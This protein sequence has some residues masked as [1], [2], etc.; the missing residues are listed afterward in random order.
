MSETNGVAVD[1]AIAD[2]GRDVIL[3]LRT[4]G[5]D[6]QSSNVMQNI[7]EAERMWGSIGAVEPPYNP[8]TLV[9]L[10]EHS[11]SLRQNVDAYVT[12]IDAFGH[13]FEPVLDLDA[14][15]ADDKIANE[16]MTERDAADPTTVADPSR[17]TARPTEDEI[18]ARKK[19]LVE[20]MREERIRLE[21]FFE[22]ST[23]DISFS[24]LRRRT[25]QDIETIGNGYWEVIRDE[26]G[27][28][29]QFEYM[30][31]F[32]IRLLPLDKTATK[33]N[34]RMK[35]GHFDYEEVNVHRRFR[36]FAQVFENRTM[37]FKEFGDPRRFSRK[38][39]R[40][41][42]DGEDFSEEQIRFGDG[43]AT[44][45][46]HFKIH[47]PRSAYGVPRWI[48][49]LLAVLGS[50][51]AEEINYLYFE[52]KSVPP[53]ALLVSGGRVTDETV[54]RIESHIQNEIQ[55]KR[56]FHKVL[57]LEAESPGAGSTLEHSGRMKIE[58]KPLTAAQHNDALFQNYDERNLDKVG[59][60]FRLPRL[61]RGD[62]RDF[63]RATAEAALEFAEMQVFG[64][65]RDEFDFL[66]NRK[67][68]PELDIR[69]WKYKSHAPTTRNPR[70][71]GEIVARLSE[72]NVLT[73]AEAR[74]F[75]EVIFN[76]ELRKDNAPWTRQP[77]AFTLAGI[78]PPEELAAP[79]MARLDGTTAPPIIPAVAPPKGSS[80]TGTDVAVIT[81]VNEARADEM[82]GPL[83]R[84]GP[85]GQMVEDPDGYLTVAEFKAKR[86]ARGESLGEAQG[87]TAA[88][89]GLQHVPG[90]DG[91]EQKADATTG[92][93]ATGG[94]LNLGGQKDKLRR[95]PAS[96][97]QEAVYL[98][99]LRKALQLAEELEADDAEL[100]ER[101]RL[102]VERA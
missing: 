43:L 63:N 76:R 91:G 79:G 66:I 60:A 31:S 69:F 82:R 100:E 44:E 28:I 42:K 98:L 61:L 99:R 10:L 16:L 53:L 52:N 18:A 25:R 58:L 26:G 97:A 89:G 35:T 9:G 23:I 86:V 51:Q 93:L 50:R 90:V 94:G 22:F 6:R 55:G 101:L 54:K 21:H 84:K 39:G 65:E 8:Q 77:A 72:S 59:Q 27:E 20:R 11:N 95:F 14:A 74:D 15:D 48:G 68:L 13:R 3:K 46:L 7:D 62:I 78:Q 47:S 36:R 40:L 38:D 88:T 33:V 96:I 29:A 64:P 71:L 19:E 41:L 1:G 70:E 85:D 80:L 102:G 92:D 12:N 4:V 75:A 73:P 56:N 5:G 81:T 24:T 67:I 34:V 45:I 17:Q 87:E 30:P 49:N 83:M 2:I 57:I 32:T 37:F